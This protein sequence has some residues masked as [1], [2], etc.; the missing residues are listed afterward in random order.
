MVPTLIGRY[1]GLMSLEE[2]SYCLHTG[3]L[4]FNQRDSKQQI[5]LPIS[6]AAFSSQVADIIQNIRTRSRDTDKGIWILPPVQLINHSDSLYPRSARFLDS[7]SPPLMFLQSK[8]QYMLTRRQCTHV[9]DGK[10][11]CILIQAG[12]GRKKDWTWERLVGLDTGDYEGERSVCNGYG[13]SIENIEEL[14]IENA[15]RT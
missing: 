9:E 3:F 11:R 13:D 12:V 4:T 14:R 10:I 2:E 8:F 15:F 1:I 6:Q 5:N 7:A